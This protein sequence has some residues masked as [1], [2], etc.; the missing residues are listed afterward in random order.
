MRE[1]M[2]WVR[3][4]GNVVSESERQCGVSEAVS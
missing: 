4:R 2:W 3:V 1:A